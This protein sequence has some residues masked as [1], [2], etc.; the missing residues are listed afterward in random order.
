M[1]KVDRIRLISIT[2]LS[3]RAHRVISYV[4]L[5]LVLSDAAWLRILACLALYR[6]GGKS[7]GYVAAMLLEILWKTSANSNEPVSSCTRRT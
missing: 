6:Y 2:R 7:H 1:G 5:L 3:E 4:A